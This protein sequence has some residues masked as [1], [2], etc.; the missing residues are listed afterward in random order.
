MLKENNLLVQLFF[1]V[2]R[3]L[4]TRWKVYLEM[5][6]E[7]LV[8]VQQKTPFMSECRSTGNQ[9]VPAQ[10]RKYPQKRVQQLGPHAQDNS[11]SCQIR[12]QEHIP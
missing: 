9:I 1:V 3:Q 4:Y 12:F 2:R 6:Y 7:I 8:M 10:I 5:E 11:V